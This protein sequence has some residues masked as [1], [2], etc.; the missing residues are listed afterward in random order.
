MLEP[1]AIDAHKD[2]ERAPAIKRA[3]HRFLS[4]FGTNGGTKLGIQ[5]TIFGKIG[6]ELVESF[7]APSNMKLGTQEVSEGSWVMAVKVVSDSVWSRIKRGDI[8]GFSIGGS[9]LVRG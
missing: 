6:L 2:F 5:H 8:T 1:N 7:I 9:A 4:R 3:A